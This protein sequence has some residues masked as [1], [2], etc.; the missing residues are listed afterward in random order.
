MKK[1]TIILS[2]LFFVACKKDSGI[3]QTDAIPQ[4][5]S[6]NQAFAKTPV[7][8]PF[9][10]TLY[11]SIDPDPSI[12]PTACTGDLP[13]LANPGHFMHGQ[14]TH[15]GELNWQQSRLQDT[16]CNLSFATMQLTTSISGQ[17]AAANGD[18]IYYT[19]NDVFDVTNLIFQSGTTGTMQVTWTITGGT[20]RFEGASGSFT[21][22][23]TVSFITFTFSFEA[24]GTITY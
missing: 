6:T 18:L 1:L 15:L 16:S 21:I 22:N 4:G 17:F 9:A 20:G 11:S 7:T 19:G 14:V 13:G 3:A 8:R 10:A 12:P 23:G 2:L 24:V 5:S